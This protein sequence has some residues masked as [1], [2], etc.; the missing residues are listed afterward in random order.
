MCCVVINIIIIIVIFSVCFG[1]YIKNDIIN[2]IIS[3][4]NYYTKLC[5]HAEIFNMIVI[6]IVTLFQMWMNNKEM[7]EGYELDNY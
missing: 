1:E 2:T 3:I 5:I 7:K 4:L 6:V